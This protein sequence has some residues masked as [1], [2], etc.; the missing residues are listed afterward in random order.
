MTGAG[1]MPNIGFILLTHNFPQRVRRLV[2]RLG[3]IY[4]SPPIVVH[5]DLGKSPLDLSDFSNV[6]V[7]ENYIPTTWGHVSVTK[8]LLTSMRVMHAPG[9]PRWIAVLS[10]ADY[11]VADAEHV[12]RDLN[13]GGREAY[14]HCELIH[15]EKILR[16]WHASCLRSYWNA[17]L[18]LPGGAG[19]YKYLYLPFRSP[20][21]PFPA[22]L[23]CY[24]GSAYFTASYRAAEY[25]LRWT[26][27]NPWLLKYLN[28]RFA[29]DEMYFQ[30][31]LGTWREFV[32]P[33]GIGTEEILRQSFRYIAW[34]GG[35]H[36]SN[37]EPEEVGRVIAS[38]AHFAR[39]FAPDS[40]ACSLI[41]ERLGC[42]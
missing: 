37:I 32:A 36:P 41:D 34:N 13:Q 5:H 16:E 26:D 20:L 31:V 38:G 17:Q 19:K 12:L 7:L 22:K 24:A 4:S 18:R 15:P 30:T 10:G 21:C 28:T 6:R 25:I 3:Q 42:H 29:T 40:P 9:G 39:K 35:T 27:G 8:A 14:I 33:T 11:P 23:N 1:C 2:G